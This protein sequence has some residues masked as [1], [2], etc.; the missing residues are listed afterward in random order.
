M[1]YSVVIEKSAL[2]FLSKL[3]KRPQNEIRRAIDELADNPRPV[4]Y[5]KLVGGGGFY[6]IKAGQYRV[7]YSV[8]D[9]IL[10]VTVV[11]LAK[12][13]EHTNSNTDKHSLLKV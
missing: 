4:G 10:L 7:I 11:T 2:K 6:R 9:N 5:K 3:E 1:K 12:R 13:N 8:L